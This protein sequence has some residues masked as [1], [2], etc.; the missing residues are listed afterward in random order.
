MAEAHLRWSN[1][2]E[3]SPS[4]LTLSEVARL[5]N[6]TKELSRKLGFARNA[7][8][9]LEIELRKRTKATERLEREKAK[10]QSLVNKSLAKV[11]PPALPQFG[12]SRICQAESLLRQR[13]GPAEDKFHDVIPE[14]DGLMKAG[15][16][17]EH[18][19]DTLKT[20]VQQLEK[21]RDDAIRELSTLPTMATPTGQT[22]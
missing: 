6:E 7:K 9:G 2:A 1:K 15:Q 8:L 21:E 3:N 18:G 13:L 10:L 17:I 14:R 4:D 5:H 22:E 16:Q 11:L 20:L 19:S 12:S